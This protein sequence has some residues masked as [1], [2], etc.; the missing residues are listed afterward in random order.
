M[1]IPRD[2]GSHTDTKATQ[3]N[4]VAVAAAAV[5]CVCCCKQRKKAAELLVNPRVKMRRRQGGACKLLLLLLLLCVCAVASKGTR[6][7]VG[8]PS[9][10][11][12]NPRVVKKMLLCV[13]VPL[14]IAAA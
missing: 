14:Q 5:V 6:L 2:M 12:V 1:Q 7:L 3:G 9:W 10:T 8:G 4:A 11:L 13:R